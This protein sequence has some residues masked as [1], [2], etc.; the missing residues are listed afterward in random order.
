MVDRAEASVRAVATAVPAGTP[1]VSIVIVGLNARDYVRQSIQSMETADWGHY[2]YEVVYVD[3]GSKDGSPEMVTEQFPS[4]VVIVNSSNLGFCKAAN[5][6]ARRSRGRHL[7]FINDDTIVRGDAISLLVEYLDTHP[8][9]GTVGSRLLYP[10]GR[11]QFSGR[12]F[13][14]LVN[15]IW[16]R[17]SILTKVFPSA[18][19]VKDYLYSDRLGE[20]DAFDVDWVSAAGQIVRRDVFEKIGGYAEDYYYWHEAVFCDRIVATGK[21]VLLH[22]RSTIIHFEGQGSGTRRTFKAQRFHIVDFHTGAFR[23]YCEHH[24]LSIVHP[25]RYVAA[26]ALTTRAA[27]LLAAA[28]LRTSW[29]FIGSARTTA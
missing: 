5:Q 1:D 27:C 16:G 25:S 18:P 23:C 20:S 11:E 22:P 19:W 17:R 28:G 13:P 2:T 3:N 14:A 7:Y 6:G 9:A 26:V 15:G 4:A 8:D 21:R 12:R 29:H 10:D 24:R